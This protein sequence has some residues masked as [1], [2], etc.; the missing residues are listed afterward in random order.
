MKGQTD[1]P[2]VSNGKYQLS[3]R[4]NT[5]LIYLP[6][7]IV[8]DTAFPLKPGIIDIRIEGPCLVIEEPK[9]K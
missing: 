1:E 3:S 5:G 7:E 6:T 9:K 2:D 8:L 4:S